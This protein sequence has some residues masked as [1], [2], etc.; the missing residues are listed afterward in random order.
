M[1]PLMEQSFSYSDIYVAP[2]TIYYG[3]DKTVLNIHELN[4]RRRVVSFDE[5]QTTTHNV[6][7]RTSLSH[8]ERKATWYNGHE[9]QVMKSLSRNEGRMVELGL[10]TETDWS[11]NNNGTEDEFT[12][13]RGLEHKTRPGLQTKR[14]NR[15]NAWS[16]VFREIGYQDIEEVT[17]NSAI[18]EEYQRF[19]TPCQETAHTI[20]QQDALD[21][22]TMWNTNNDD[23]QH[24][25]RIHINTQE[26][27]FDSTMYRNEIPSLKTNSEL[28][29][30]PLTTIF[31]W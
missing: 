25:R 3:N 4:E 19:S 20:A 1:A 22:R 8:Q 30:S 31:A 18:A 24:T 26:S 10:L 2:E 17:N 11:N 23:E 12:T 28:G 6:I 7:H 21:V 16:A 29:T 14:D 13:I 5:T 15:K 27:S 9:L